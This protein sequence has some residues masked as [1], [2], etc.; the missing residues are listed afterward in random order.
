MPLPND[1]DSILKID[2]VLKQYKDPVRIFKELHSVFPN[3]MP[4][5]EQ[6]R[7]SYQP[8]MDTYA[9]L[10]ALSSEKTASKP[11]DSHLSQNNNAKHGNRKDPLEVRRPELKVNNWRD[12]YDDPTCILLESLGDTK[13]VDMCE[14]DVRTQYESTGNM[15]FVLE[16]FFRRVDRL[17][18]G[19]SEA[20]LLHSKP[21]DK[22]Y[23]LYDGGGLYLV[24]N[25]DNT[26]QW[27]FQ[28]S[29]MVNTRKRP[30]KV[31]PDF[32]KQWQVKTRIH[33]CRAKHIGDYPKI[34]L[35]YARRYREAAN[36]LLVKR[37]YPFS[38]KN[39]IEAIID[40]IYDDEKD[41]PIP[42]WM[43]QALADGFK[44]YYSRRFLSGKQDTTLDAVF[45]IEGKNRFHEFSDFSI[46]NRT[47]VNKAREVQWYCNLK[48]APALEFARRII[49][50]EY[51]ADGSNF[52][53]EELY[54]FTH[55]ELKTIC[56]D[57]SRGKYG[58][59]A[60]WYQDK[61]YGYLANRMLRDSFFELIE[62]LDES[63]KTS[64]KIEIEAAM[65]DTHKRLFK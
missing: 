41:V 65:N 50:C 24:V 28:F 23:T 64:L 15:L 1:S 51:T 43:A 5:S 63:S 42:A 13:L 61:E 2:F 25:P 4:S 59:Y 62:I 8:G 19:L 12:N 52:D 35:H 10:N 33:K 32:S 47:L 36:N 60:K 29:L 56:Q 53:D 58:S 26:K 49:E 18:G 45:G 16:A 31:N 57:E 22:A 39:N 11:Q 38:K 7:A 27:Y 44:H 30:V 34:N 54:R 48:F 55:A 46:D 37:K 17:T 14:K 40:C 6:F 21:K 20:E 3:H 9:L